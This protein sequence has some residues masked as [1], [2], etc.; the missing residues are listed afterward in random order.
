MMIKLAIH[1]QWA[2][3]I[4]IEKFFLKIP[5]I[6]KIMLLT[7]RIDFCYTLSMLLSAG[8]SLHDA[9]SKTIT[10]V[11]LPYSRQC[12]THAFKE[13]ML[14]KTL[15]ST[16][17]K[18]PFFSRAAVQAIASAEKTGDLDHAFKRIGQ[19]YS[20]D[21]SVFS[22]HLGKFIEPFIIIFLGSIIGTIVIAIYLPIFQLGS[23]Y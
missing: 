9:L 11:S 10:T 3:E 20:Q 14:G 16:L 19:Q 1:Y 5:I 4:L 12:L 23:L 17:K 13:V 7:S 15:S 21:L 22:D 2:S 18:T 6:G 8:V